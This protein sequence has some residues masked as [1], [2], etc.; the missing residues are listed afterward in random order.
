[1][2]AKTSPA[3]T[4]PAIRP[5]TTWVISPTQQQVYALLEAGPEGVRAI[6]SVAL[7]RLV[8]EIGI[9][10]A[11]EL[12][13]LAAAEQVRELF[14]LQV[15]RHDRVD[16]SVLLDWTHALTTLS[17][18][19]RARHLHGLD[20][21]LLGYLL[22]IHSTIYLAQVEDEPVPEEPEGTFF[23]TPDGWFILDLLAPTET[24]VDQL[25]ELIRNLY[26]IDADEARVLLQNLMWELPTELEES[27][28]RWRNARLQDLGFAD[29]LEALLVYA[30]LDP[31]SVRPDEG[32]ADR[33]LTSDPDP[34]GR[35]DK[36][37]LLP[38]GAPRSFWT[39]ALEQID[40]LDERERLARAMMFVAN[41]TL[42]AD[43]IAPHDDER[44]EASLQELRGR[45]SL[46]LEYLADGDLA[47]T[48][49]ILA[50]VALLRLARLGYSLI[51]QVGA[52]IIPLY[53]DRRLGRRPRSLVLLG[54][55]LERRLNL[56]LSQR[57][58][59]AATE[60]PRPFTSPADLNLAR[61]WVHEAR[62]TAALVPPSSWP[63]E[64]P[65]NLSLPSIFRSRVVASALDLPL[66]D[67]LNA[68]ALEK[69]RTH[70]AP[71]EPSGFDEA[72]AAAARAELKAQ[73]GDLSAEDRASATRLALRWFQDLA[74]TLAP[75]DPD[76]PIDP[77]FIDGLHVTT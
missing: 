65:D 2:P 64:L 45:L 66:D 77:R 6:S 9:H 5:Q 15:W 39:Q 4:S 28:L 69:L 32:T 21:E 7:H 34:V 8:N 25:I 46:G 20:I 27:S 68:E 26:V 55:P 3:E 41:R 71:K 56:L 37:T 43:R 53:R 30:P 13:E 23:Q 16:A 35:P 31:E 33:P 47:R 36:E 70:L 11:A 49:A 76:A 1:S 19:A 14:D 74:E 58:L 59:F 50:K 61:E 22:R 57:P 10:E 72:I 40:D 63:E 29:P 18:E 62:Q 24:E 75:L 44:A 12:L 38:K 67:A 48:P 52:P 42:A 54:H 51:L 17:D 60:P 73:T